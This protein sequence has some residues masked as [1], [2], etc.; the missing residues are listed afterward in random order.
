[1]ELT[2]ITRRATVIAAT[3]VTK[4]VTAAMGFED[5]ILKTVDSQEIR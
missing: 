2:Y 5:N 1:M 4:L 3:L